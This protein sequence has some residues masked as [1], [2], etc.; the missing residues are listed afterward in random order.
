[1]HRLIS[2]AA[3]GTLVDHTDGDGLNNQK[4]NLRLATKAQ[5]NANR[6]ASGKSTFLGV[7]VST[8]CKYRR[9]KQGELKT[10]ISI[11]WRALLSHNNKQIHLG[12]FPFT[13]DGEIAAA[14]VYD[15]AAKRYH[16]EFANL[17]F[18]S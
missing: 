18:K 4:I 2:K 9:N 16:G 11:K 1:M 6:N 12:N 8:T 17:N 7:Y 5:N 15:E 3:S 13:P 10:H 14:K